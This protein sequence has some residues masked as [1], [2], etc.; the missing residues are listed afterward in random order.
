MFRNSFNVY[1]QAARGVIEVLYPACG[2]MSSNF[3]ECD[4]GNMRQ[5]LVAYDI[6]DNFVKGL[7]R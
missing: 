4:F 3:F 5:I 6:G 7:S 1:V 2:I